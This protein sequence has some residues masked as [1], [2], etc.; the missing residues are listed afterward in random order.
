[1][2]LSPFIENGILRV[3]GR[4]KNANLSFDTKHPILLP[5]QHF[6][7][8][9]IITFIHLKCLHGGPKLTENMLRQVYWVVNSKHQIKRIINKCITC[10]KL[11][12]S[13]M[14]QLMANLPKNRVNFQEKPFT[15]IAIDYTGAVNYKFS[16]GR[17]CKTSKAY[18]A[19]FVC[20]SVKAI[21]IELVSDLTADAFVA[22]LRRMIARRGEV[23]NIY[24]DNGTCKKGFDGIKP[25]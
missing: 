21:H 25:K 18:I 23:K 7:T 2:K 15:N 10:F 3:G 9:L 1:M 8:D 17:G 13:T 22:A 19:I 11:K 16:K 5:K 14:T 24:S 6:V 20:M 4:L 12:A